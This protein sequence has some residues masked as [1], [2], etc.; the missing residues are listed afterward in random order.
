MWEQGEENK[1]RRKAKDTVWLSPEQK[2]MAELARS[3]AR[4]F[5]HGAGVLGEEGLGVG[6]GEEEELVG[7]GSVEEVRKGG[8][9]RRK[10]GPECRCARCL[11]RG[12]ITCIACSE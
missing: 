7:G 10:D 9:G 2:K 8:V 6:E 3:R 12:Y 5:G 1:Y 4:F 11:G